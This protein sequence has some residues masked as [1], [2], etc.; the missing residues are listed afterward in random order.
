MRILPQGLI[1]AITLAGVMAAVFVPGSARALDIRKARQPKDLSPTLQN[2]LSDTL[3]DKVEP[4]LETEETRKSKGEAYIDLQPKFEY[5]PNYGPHHQ[6]VVSAKLGGAEY[7]PNKGNNPKGEATGKLKYLV[8]TYQLNDV[9]KWVEVAKPKWESQDLGA[10]AGKKMTASAQAA[11]KRKEALAKAKA[12]AAA[13]QQGLNAQTGN[14]SSSPSTASS[15]V[16]QQG[17][18]QPPSGQQ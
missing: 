3:S 5:L 1:A 12:R 6:L 13:M 18:S 15:A 11:E 2:S 8:F 10:L 4:Y 9:G 7:I 17:T 14:T 16:S